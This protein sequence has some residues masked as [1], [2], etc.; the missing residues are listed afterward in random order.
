MTELIQAA[1]VEE[2]HAG[3]RRFLILPPHALVTPLAR[4]RARDL[5]VVLQQPG[6]N[7]GGVKTSCP[8][9]GCAQPCGG[10]GAC[11]RPTGLTE[12]QVRR[13]VAGIILK[14]MPDAF[15]PVLVRQVTER[16]MQQLRTPKVGRAPGG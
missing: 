2:A 12:A 5:G 4:E 1:D 8:G 13:V 14:A 10:L 9:G 11:G 15:S 16:V 7:G 3:G 6:V